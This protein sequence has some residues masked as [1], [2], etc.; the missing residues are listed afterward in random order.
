MFRLLFQIKRFLYI[1]IR[2]LLYFFKKNYTEALKSF[3]KKKEDAL[4][5]KEIPN[6]NR[7]VE[8]KTDKEVYD[9]YYL[10][11][12]N[13][14]PFYYN[15]ILFNIIKKNKIDIFKNLVD[16]FYK[17]YEFKVKIGLELEFYILNENEKNIDIL[18]ELKK[19]FS[20]LDV[21]E[22]EGKNQFELKTTPTTDLTLFVE[23]YLDIIKNL[24]KFCKKNNLK[25]ELNSS[26][27][28]DDC[29]SSLQINF[30]IIDKDGNNLFA[31]ENVG[32][33]KV[34]ESGLL[35]NCLSGLLKNINNNLLLYIKDEKSL[36]RFSVEK[37][38]I[39]VEKD[40]YP[41]PTYISWGVNNRTT[42]IRIPTP[43]NIDIKKYMEE[44]K[45]NR[46]IEFRVPSSDA[47]I[48]LVMI[49]VLSSIAEGVNN[50]LIP[51]IEKTSFDVL[52]KNDNLKKIE[53]NF[54][55]LNDEFS[56][57]ENVLWY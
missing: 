20:S 21:A 44:D 32:G 26:P 10:Y 13:E 17:T 38:K 2:D 14:K 7:E 1:S 15:S 6:L 47:D 42:C 52:I 9:F 33:S 16:I 41:S 23:N 3:K 53:S 5:K 28:E 24:K 48:Y 36:K 37:N 11:P 4:L 18:K 57:S 35:L 50:N 39:I 22:E 55:I 51:E 27:F 29:G 43:S 30:S 19:E 54:D 25:L 46:R 49:G 56:V 31:R 40:K 12:K 8:L 34:E 45:K